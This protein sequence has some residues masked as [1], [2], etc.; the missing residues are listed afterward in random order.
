MIEKVKY[1]Q[2]LTWLK[3][4]LNTSQNILEIG[5][6]YAPIA[7]RREGYSCEIIDAFST[8][9]LKDMAKRNGLDSS[10]IEDVD[11][12]WKGESLSS[13]IKK[14]SYY[15]VIIA[16]HVIEHIPNII[17]FLQESESLLKDDGC[18]VMAV[19]DSRKCFDCLRLP[20]KTGEILNSFYEKRQVHSSSSVFDFHSLYSASNGL[21]SWFDNQKIS[22]EGIKLKGNLTNSYELFKNSITNSTEYLDVHGW[23]FTPYSF[24]A[25]IK[26]L[27]GLSLMPFSLY[28]FAT[29]NAHEFYV[30]L[31]KCTNKKENI[32]LLDNYSREELH[33]NIRKDLCEFVENYENKI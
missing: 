15:D 31:K 25:N 19:P 10:N 5:P 20:T 4:F 22:E 2:R 1:S 24:L 28:D 29:G 27:Q 21:E 13:L 8:D 26:E 12:I 3:K 18:L 30:V 17:E 32:D 23:V 7:P 16:S 33:F 14:K 9:Y 6:S 11:Y